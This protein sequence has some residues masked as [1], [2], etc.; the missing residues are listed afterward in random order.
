[1]GKSIP[2]K[3]EALYCSTGNLEI[4]SA[5]VRTTGVKVP[6]YSFMVALSC[7]SVVKFFV[8]LKESAQATS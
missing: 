5:L 8:F 7:C 4:A 3:P 6:K 1:M 2:L